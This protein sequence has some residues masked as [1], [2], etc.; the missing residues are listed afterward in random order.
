M[1]QTKNQPFEE[2]LTS[3]QEI[4]LPITL[5]ED[6]SPTFSAQNKPLKDAQLAA[7]IASIDTE[8]DEFTEFVPCFRL[9]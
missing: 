4:D 9:K 2:F 8:I 3:F 7:F 5:T 6:L 1:L